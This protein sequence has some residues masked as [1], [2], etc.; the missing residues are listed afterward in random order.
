MDSGRC[1]SIVLV[2]IE[3]VQTSCHREDHCIHCD[4]MLAVVE[5]VRYDLHCEIWQLVHLLRLDAHEYLARRLQVAELE[6]DVLFYPVQIAIHRCKHPPRRRHQL[7][8]H[9]AVVRRPQQ[10]TQVIIKPHQLLSRL[11]TVTPQLRVRQLCHVAYR[12]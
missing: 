4:K 8:S 1:Q 6:G 3:L 5:V 10:V 7:H 2:A 11:L 12:P 9:L